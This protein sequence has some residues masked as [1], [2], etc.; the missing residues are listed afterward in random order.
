MG[1]LLEWQKI[2][3]THYFGKSFSGH[4]GL[5]KWLDKK[6]YK[7]NKQNDS[8]VFVLSDIEK[9]EV[10]SFYSLK[11]GQEPITNAPSDQRQK[12]ANGSSGGLFPCVNI[13]WLGV[14]AKYPRKRYGEATLKEALVTCAGIFDATGGY[15]VVLTPDDGVEEFYTKYGFEEIGSGISKR[16]LMPSKTIFDFREMVQNKVMTAT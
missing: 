1:Q 10:L 16:M 14:N 13:Q 8:R 11:L 2:N 9:S 4:K 12:L 6:A 15:G 5:D 7:A 3:N